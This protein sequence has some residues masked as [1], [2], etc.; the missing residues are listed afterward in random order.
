MILGRWPKLMTKV[1]EV[2]HILPKLLPSR[3]FNKEQ[4][5]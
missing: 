3:K 2:A 4:V 5:S 1:P